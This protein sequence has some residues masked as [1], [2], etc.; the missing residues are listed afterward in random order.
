VLLAICGLANPPFSVETNSVKLTPRSRFA[1]SLKLRS[2]WRVIAFVVLCFLLSGGPKSLADGPRASSAPI[3]VSSANVIDLWPDT[4][5]Q[6]DGTDQ[7]ERDT[8][9]SKGGMVAGGAVIRLGHVSKP[10]LHLYFPQVESAAN[11]KADTIILICPGGGYSILAW[12]L[13]GTEIAQRFN[14][15]G[16]SAAVVKYRVPTRQSEEPWLAPVQDIQRAISQLRTMAKNEGKSGLRVGLVGFSAGGNA[17]ARTAT[18]GGQRFYEPIDGIDKASCEV[19]FAGLVYP[20]LM[21]ENPSASKPNSNG[22]KA[23]TMGIIPDLTITVSTPP[24]F[25]AHAID[26]RISCR[27]SIEL[28]SALQANGIPAELHIFASGGHGFGARDAALPAANW[29]EQMARWLTVIS[30]AH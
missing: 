12:D 10:Q 24:M 8:T 4:P 27:N 21:V 23:G 7:Q 25:F 18:A 5:P 26:D 11:A 16:Y 13:E 19:D 17:A 22:V 20:W 28:F 3:D 2:R 9:D 14:S 6:W 1:T 15:M 29:P 30:P